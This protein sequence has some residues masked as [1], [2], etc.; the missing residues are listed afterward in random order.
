MKNSRKYGMVPPK[1]FCKC[2]ENLLGW[3]AA[4][5]CQIYLAVRPEVQVQAGAQ[6]Y[7]FSKP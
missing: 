4:Q 1:L 5:T 6:V 3:E 2:E 7:L